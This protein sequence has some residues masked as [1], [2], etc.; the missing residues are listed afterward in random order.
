MHKSIGIAAAATTILA[1]LAASTAPLSGVARAGEPL[2][3]PQLYQVEVIVFRTL[4]PLGV[5]EDWRAQT[6]AEQ[7]VEEDTPDIDAQPLP[8][9][10]G[11]PSIQTLSAQ[12]FQL[13]RIDAALRRS[14]NY[15]VLAH[16]AWTQ[17]ATPRGAGLATP[18][19]ELG[20]DDAQLRGDVTLEQGRYLYLNLNLAWTPDD[21]PFS[22]L[23]AAADT[24][25]AVTFTLREKRRLRP[26][27]RHYI[28]HPAFGV[29]AIVTPVTLAE[30]PVS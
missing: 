12:Q 6:I 8:A 27:E 20:L 30:T 4:T 28:D 25:P 26:F 3:P 24:D 9:A 10:T 11:R 18:L 19:N 5:A 2:A 1:A 29:I 7:P 15:Q 23:G 14:A 22:L 21:P 16:A 13:A 17:P